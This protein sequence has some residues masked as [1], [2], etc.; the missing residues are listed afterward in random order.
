MLLALIPGI[1][2][3][4]GLGLMY[5]GDYIKGGIFL[6]IGFPMM[7]GMVLLFTGAVVFSFWAII[8]VGLLILLGLA[9]LAVFVIQFFLTYA[10]AVVRQ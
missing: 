3:V 6:V 10:M 4:M 8:V 9:Y 7:V 5:L 1:F 2:G